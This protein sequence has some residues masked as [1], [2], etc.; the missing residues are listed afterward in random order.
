MSSWV[1]YSVAVYAGLLSA[2][3][4]MAPKPQA[5]IGSE[6]TPAHERCPHEIGH[7]LKAAPTASPLQMCAPERE[8]AESY[9]VAGRLT[10]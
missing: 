3:A 8:P 2:G 6:P 1:R 10:R 7:P 9:R 4:L 5:S